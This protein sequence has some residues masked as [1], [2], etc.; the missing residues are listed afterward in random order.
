MRELDFA[1]YLALIVCLI[2]YETWVQREKN[3]SNTRPRYY[4][5][6]ETILRSM[7]ELSTANSLATKV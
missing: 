1:S 4:I 2:C 3:P 7:S 5:L 6:K